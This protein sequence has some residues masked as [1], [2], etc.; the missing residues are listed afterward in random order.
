VQIPVDERD[1]RTGDLVCARL[2]PGQSVTM[3]DVTGKSSGEEHPNATAYRRAAAAF[4]SRD[5]LTIADLVD[6]D[7]VWHVPGQHP[8]A[9]DYRGRDELLGFLA[10]LAGLGFVLAEEDVFGND[11]HVC[12]LSQMSAR[13]P[14]LE[15]TTRVVSIFRFRDQRQLERWFYPDDISAWNAIF[16]EAS[17]GS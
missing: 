10:R 15:V 11:R 8:L 3:A 2:A 9:G 1:G 6:P 14:G 17:P 5:L 13:R 16:T 7:V 12:A 4:R